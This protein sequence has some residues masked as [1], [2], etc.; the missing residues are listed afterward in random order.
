M[1]VSEFIKSFLT[2]NIIVAWVA[3]IFAAVVAPVIIRI[4]TV[5]RKNKEF[6]KR[7]DSANG[8]ILDTIRPFV[9]QRI[10]LDKTEI[11]GIRK[12]VA[13]KNGIQEKYLYSDFEIMN[14]LIY[15][16]ATT[17]FITEEDKK[18]LSENIIKMFPAVNEIENEKNA[19][20]KKNVNI[21]G[22][23][24]QVILIVGLLVF[25]L[26]AYNINPQKAED[27]NSVL[28]IIV[29]LPIMAALILCMGFSWNVSIMI[30]SL[31]ANSTYEMLR[32]ISGIINIRKRGKKGKLD[33]DTEEE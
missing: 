17:R 2:N 5:R 14:Q 31:V 4:I 29:V 13:N 26:I 32:S 22:G 20:I 19:G 1:S 18:R 21:K 3:P 10:N 12:A 27:S 8:E 7:V 33:A 15:S 25:S 16:I 30:P 9:I 24:V 23:I 6:L 28:A 11:H